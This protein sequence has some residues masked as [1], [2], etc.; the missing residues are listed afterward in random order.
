MSI[1]RLIA[2]KQADKDARDLNAIR[3]RTLGAIHQ[4][5]SANSFGLE[6]EQEGSNGIYAGDG[7][8]D[9]KPVGKS[10]KPRSKRKPAQRSKSRSEVKKAASGFAP[11]G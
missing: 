7:R 5:R 9:Q 11:E 8:A 10:K 1:E 2:K 4:E 6:V 3:K